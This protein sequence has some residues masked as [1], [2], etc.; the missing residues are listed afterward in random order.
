MSRVSE[1]HHG[2]ASGAFS[3]AQSRGKPNA[4]VPG[5]VSVCLMVRR[6]VSRIP[7]C[8]GSWESGTGE[9]LRPHAW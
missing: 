2:P 5:V 1:T 4:P 8:I 7:A 9:A 6:A 3:C